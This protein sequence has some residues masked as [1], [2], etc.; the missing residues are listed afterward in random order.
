M[1]NQRDVS[2]PPDISAMIAS[3]PSLLLFLLSSKRQL[4]PYLHR[5]HSSV[6]IMHSLSLQR[7]LLF[8]SYFSIHPG[9]GD[10]SVTC[11]SKR[12]VDITKTK[13]EGSLLVQDL[14]R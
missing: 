2:Y 14:S 4:V 13:E 11:T 12:S 10:C 3:S 1:T 7:L 9:S 5:F 8:F 6:V